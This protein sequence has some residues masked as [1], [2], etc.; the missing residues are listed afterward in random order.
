MLLCLFQFSTF[1]S[2]PTSG[3]NFT[4]IL[5]AAFTYISCACS[6]FVLTFQVFVLQAQDC[7]H[8]SCM[9]NV[10]EIDPRYL[11]AL[12]TTA[13]SKIKG[14]PYLT[15]RPQGEGGRNFVTIVLKSQSMTMYKGPDVKNFYYQKT[16]FIYGLPYPNHF[17][18]CKLMFLLIKLTQLEMNQSQLFEIGD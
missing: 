5:C 11:G 12:C 3:I 14:H 9:Q 16:H 2:P 13:K 18:I 17:Y 4:N 6:I 8:K 10:H 1:S 15:S 7:W